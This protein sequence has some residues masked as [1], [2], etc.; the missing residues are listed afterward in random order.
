MPF[1]ETRTTFHK[2]G[3]W[4]S[5]C[6]LFEVAALMV[7]VRNKAVPT[8]QATALLE[9]RDLENSNSSPT[10]LSVL[11]SLLPGTVTFWLNAC[12]GPVC[13]CTCVYTRM[14]VHVYG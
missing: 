7:D 13:V 5:F 1:F 12:S 4:V 6:T 2:L 9:Y 8:P 11:R 14:D 3:G 10:F